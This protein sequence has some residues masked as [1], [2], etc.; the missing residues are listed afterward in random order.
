M[1]GRASGFREF[2]FRIQNSELRL[3]CIL[4]SAFCVFLVGC[5]PAVIAQPKTDTSAGGSALEVVM[6][7]KPARKTLTLIT[8][9]PARVEPLE[10]TPIHS[11]LA[12]YVAE[13]IA[14]YGDQVAK[15]QPLI[16][17]SAPEVDAEVAQKNALLAQAKA[18]LVQAEAA[19]KASQAAITTA[20]S[21]LTQA[22]AR[23]ERAQADHERWRL[24]A[25]RI[26]ELA[27]GGS[28]TRQLQEETQL[29]YAAARAAQKET[30]AAIDA[31]KAAVEQ[32]E[33]QAAKAAADVEA[34]RSRVQVALANLA[35][36]EAL[37]SYLTIRAP[38]AGV[39]T[40]R[41][42]DPGHLVQPAGGE[43][44]TL[45]VVARTDKM[46][47]FVAVPEVEAG[48]VDLEDDVVVEVPSLRGAEFKGK[49]T[50]T[51]VGVDAGNRSLETIID[52]DN[53]GGRL[54]PGMYATAKIKLAEQK[55]VLT[56]PG[57]AVV[58]QGK[59]A[60]CYRL[61]NGKATKTDIQVGIKVGDDFEIVKGLSESD[62]VILNKAATLKDGQPV[63]VLKPEAKK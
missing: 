7:G 18:E 22:E 23:V 38:F 26:E 57:A 62:T 50:R 29:N 45:L 41:R 27:A 55:D 13:V 2:E 40:Q 33:A 42:V 6:A 48:Y 15:D 5:A 61:I 36:A 44:S 8:T 28:I 49:V 30:L 35:Q 19:L 12:A 24:Q 31:G 56:L 52:L 20:K 46:R 54:R 58:R 51:S 60:S 34:A 17:L 10:Q 43:N 25:A 16:K 37:R 11:K 32:S 39:V 14:D 63:E 59:E 4:H 21:Q 3:F 47:V 53:E 9:Q 1:S